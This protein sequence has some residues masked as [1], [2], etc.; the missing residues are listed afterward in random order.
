MADGY[1]P[2]CLVWSGILTDERMDSP[3]SEL[4]EYRQKGLTFHSKSR[5]KGGHSGFVAVLPPVG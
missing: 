2:G 1:F 5:R 4:K 3:G